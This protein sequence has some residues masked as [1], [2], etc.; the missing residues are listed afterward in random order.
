M[1]LVNVPAPVTTVQVPEAGAV[2]AFAASVTLATGAQRFCAGPALAADA[3]RSNTRITTSSKELFGTQG[4]LLIVQ[5]NV[6]IPTGIF[7]TVLV[8]E[9]GFVIVA[10][11][12]TTVQVPVP[13]AT[14][15]VAANVVLANAD[16]DAVHRSTSGPAAAAVQSA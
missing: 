2:A 15:A 12:P 13:G 7:V 8:A 9:F 5:R 10:V 6:V 4:P 3:L 14:A 1:A 16:P 11:P